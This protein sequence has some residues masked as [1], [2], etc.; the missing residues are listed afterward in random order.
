MVFGRMCRSRIAGS[1]VPDAIAASTYGCS[2]SVSTSERTS[3]TTRGTSVIAIAIT[4]FW[5]LARVSEI[6]AMA[7]ST[8][9]IDISPSITPIITASSRRM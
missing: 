1:R 4:T 5:R 6:S 9:G 3:R 8:D 7:S 2:R